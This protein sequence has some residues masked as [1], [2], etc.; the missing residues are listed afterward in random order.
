M[1]APIA[2][3][4]ATPPGFVTV[5]FPCLNEE[6][7]IGACVDRAKEALRTAGIEGEVL[8]VDNASTDRS[9]E[10]AAAHGARVVLETRRGYGS[11]YLRG[12]REARGE[13]VVMLDADGTYPAE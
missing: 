8:V 7:A 4:T 2:E 11:A 9:A 13:F 6:A 10:I 3:L 5:L 1:T 12:F